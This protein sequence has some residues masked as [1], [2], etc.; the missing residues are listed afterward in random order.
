MKCNLVPS[1]KKSQLKSCIE[2]FV[3]NRSIADNVSC[4][5]GDLVNSSRDLI[6]KHY[7]AALEWQLSEI[8]WFSRE[9]WSYILNSNK[10]IY[11]WLNI[12]VKKR[13]DI[14]VSGKDGSIIEDLKKLF[15]DNSYLHQSEDFF[16]SGEKEKNTTSENALKMVKMMREKS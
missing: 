6:E 4:S 3:K 1:Q 7:Q 12:D 5:P 15:E 16:Q 9:H 8:K 13:L 10:K 14:K 11:E 2:K